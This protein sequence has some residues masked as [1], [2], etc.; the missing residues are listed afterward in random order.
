MLQQNASFSCLKIGMIH[1]FLCFL[2]FEEHFKRN[3]IQPL[4]H[5]AYIVPVDKIY[6]L[7]LM[8]ILWDVYIFMYI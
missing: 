8:F 5:F 3:F 7:L 4:L 1:K 6:K 2:C